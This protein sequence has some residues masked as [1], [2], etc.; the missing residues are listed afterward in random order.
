[1][2]STNN[3]MK[4]IN[5]CFLFIAACLAGCATPFHAPSDLAHIT[6]D[7][8]DSPLAIVE[9]IWLERKNGPAVVKGYVV[10]RLGKPNTTQT[11]LDVSFYDSNGQLLRHTLAHFEPRQLRQTLRQPSPSS[12]SVIVEPLPAQTARIEVKAHEG[13]HP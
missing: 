7:R 1:M 3:P 12:Y 8:G 5:V 4:S 11:H 2:P 9:K 10:A 6:L 13:S